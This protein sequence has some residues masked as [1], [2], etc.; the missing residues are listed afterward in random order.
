MLAVP[1][2]QVRTGRGERLVTERRI[3]A[4]DS[5]PTGFVLTVACPCGRPHQV[6]VQRLPA[7]PADR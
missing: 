3:T 2:P 4:L 7:L 1:C 5:S 6:P